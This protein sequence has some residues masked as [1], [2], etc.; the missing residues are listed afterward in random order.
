MGFMRLFQGW[1]KN[2]PS[3]R[4]DASRQ[5][6]DLYWD[7]K[8][9]AL[10]ESWGE[11][12]AWHEAQFLF[13]GRSGRALDVA[14]GTGIVMEKLAAV[15]GLEIHGC[16]ISDFLIGKARQRG[17]AADRLKVCDATQ[18]PYSAGEFDF[19]YSIGSLE[20]F[21]EE[22]I[23]KCFA[24]MARVTRQASYHFMPVS[25]SGK[26]E[27][28]MKT[29]Q[30]FHNCSVAWWRQRL[31]PHFPRIVD[32]PSLWKDDISLGRWFLCFKD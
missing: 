6:L 21:T 22:G 2:G 15:S 16:D 20:H 19:S 13:G 17:I 31:A 23:G 4:A 3:G 26:D 10:L 24:E 11:G 8:M 32:L 30:S 5:D 18:L 29:L 9:A 12:N 27:G 7:P 28:W 25:R 14:C 1:R